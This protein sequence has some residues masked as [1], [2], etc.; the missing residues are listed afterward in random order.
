MDPLP[1]PLPLELREAPEDAEQ[2]PSRRA[3][4][5]DRLPEGDKRDAGGGQLL[6]GDVGGGEIA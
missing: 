6:D 2:E 1:D 4:G 5:V 3:R